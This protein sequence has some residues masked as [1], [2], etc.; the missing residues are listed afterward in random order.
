VNRS[1]LVA[2]LSPLEREE[3]KVFVE[4]L[5]ATGPAPVAPPLP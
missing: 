2:C 1:A 4:A 3:L 5:T